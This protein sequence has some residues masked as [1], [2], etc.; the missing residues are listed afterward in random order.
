MLTPKEQHVKCQDVLIQFLQVDLE[1]SLTMLKTAEIQG[2]VNPAR[3]FSLV[4]KAR[5]ALVAVR[6]FQRRIDDPKWSEIISR[7]ANEV[8]GRLEA[9]SLAEL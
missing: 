7:K 4:E 8:E 2:I 1:L 6:H 3:Y 5:R 9:H